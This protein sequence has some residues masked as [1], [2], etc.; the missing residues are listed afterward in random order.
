MAAVVAPTPLT[1][2]LLVSFG[3]FG[4]RRSGVAT[5]ARRFPASEWESGALLFI[6]GMVRGRSQQTYGR[7]P[8]TLVVA[9]LQAA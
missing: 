9:C 3:D 6:W 8:C 5:P 2:A 4:A 1:N 7:A